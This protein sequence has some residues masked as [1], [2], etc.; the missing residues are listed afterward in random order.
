MESQE[1][2]DFANSSIDLHAEESRN[3]R[4]AS[5]SSMEQEILSFIG[6]EIEFR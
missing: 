2:G 1:H 6:A 4:R 5:S 3:H